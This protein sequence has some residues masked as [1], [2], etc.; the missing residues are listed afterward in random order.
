[1]HQVISVRLGLDWSKE[2]SPR[3]EFHD[4]ENYASDQLSL[5]K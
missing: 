2:H 5:N 3:T 4:G 1:M